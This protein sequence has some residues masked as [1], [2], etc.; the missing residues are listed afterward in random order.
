MAVQI[1]CYMLNGQMWSRWFGIYCFPLWA[2]PMSV[3]QKYELHWYLFISF[4]FYSGN[5]KVIAVISAALTLHFCSSIASFILSGLPVFTIL[6]NL[7]GFFAAFSY[8]GFVSDVLQCGSD[9][10][11]V[12]PQIKEIRSSIPFQMNLNFI[13]SSV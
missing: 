3:V 4:I 8:D 11:E 13:F 9:P 1:W 7:P 2:I 6:A 5:L 10:R 12:L